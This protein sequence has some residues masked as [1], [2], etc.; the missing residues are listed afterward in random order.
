MV[1]ILEGVRPR[2]ANPEPILYA[3]VLLRRLSSLMLEIGRVV[4]GVD[5]F[6]LVI[7]E[8]DVLPA[9]FRHRRDALHCGQS[10]RW[11]RRLVDRVVRAD[12]ERWWGRMRAS[13]CDVYASADI[14]NVAAVKGSL[15]CVTIG[16]S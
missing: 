8:P 2:T 1:E 16:C 5:R 12:I 4:G 14:T 11:R 3:R 7:V 9:G 13:Y 6:T 15:M 10:I